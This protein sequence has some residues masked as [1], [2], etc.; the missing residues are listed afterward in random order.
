MYFACN[1][2]TAI[3]QEPKNPTGSS[4]MLEQSADNELVRIYYVCLRN[5]I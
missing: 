1:I 4:E 2:Q 3:D 5:F